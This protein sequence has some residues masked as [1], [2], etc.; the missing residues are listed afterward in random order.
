MEFSDDVA[1]VVF[2]WLPLLDMLKLKRVSRQF[3]RL[4]TK[5]LHVD[6]WAIRS[7]K[8]FIE[9][10]L[11]GE[12]TFEQFCDML[13]KNQAVLSGST[14]IQWALNEDWQTNMD[15]FACAPSGFSG[16]QQWL[17]VDGLPR[18]DYWPH[19][20]IEVWKRCP[21][22]FLSADHHPSYATSF[23]W[24]RGAPDRSGAA[25]FIFIEYIR[26][27]VSAPPGP[28]LFDMKTV[29]PH[30]TSL[31]IGGE[32]RQTELTY[33][34]MQWFTFK[35]QCNTFDGRMVH[36]RYFDHIVNRQ[37]VPLLIDWEPEWGYEKYK[38]RGFTLEAESKRCTAM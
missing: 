12:L 31:T 35:V 11:P 8:R 19:F 29:P 30:R 37:L 13:T 21:G 20:A 24:R 38:G 32:W 5:A 16:E 2:E 25:S 3:Y 9:P 4:V 18:V 28:G 22:Y 36:F 17:Q 34:M 14:L 26:E 1:T 15:I 33:S 6:G 7:L 10:K 23:Q 27:R